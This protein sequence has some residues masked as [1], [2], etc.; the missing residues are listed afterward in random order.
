M[1][2]LSLGSVQFGPTAYVDTFA[3]LINRKI[4]V[5]S[6]S[7]EYLAVERHFLNQLMIPL[8]EQVN[9]DEKW[10]LTTHP[11]VREAIAR[12]DVQNAREHYVLHG[13]FEHRR[14]YRIDVDE[15]WYLSAYPDVKEALQRRDFESG[16]AHFETV[17]YREGRFPFPNFNLLTGYKRAA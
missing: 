5:P 13:F 12:G 17:G 1:K 15:K 10:Y 2:S 4:L 9:V 7:S 16:Q 3:T 11:D 8:L 14:P 6:A